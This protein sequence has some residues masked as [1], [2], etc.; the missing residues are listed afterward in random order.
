MPTKKPIVLLNNHDTLDNREKRNAAEN[1]ITPTAP[2][3]HDPPPKLSGHKMASMLWKKI[4]E[5]YD[6]IDGKIATAFDEETLIN[7]VLL[8]EECEWLISIRGKVD[9]ERASVEKMIA[10]KPEIKDDAKMKNY[11][12]LL[13]QYSALLARLQGLD[14]R[15]D[16]KRKLMHTLAQSLYLTPRAR[17]GVVPPQKGTPPPADPMEAFLFRTNLNKQGVEHA[18]K[19]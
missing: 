9:K 7:F 2:L 8:W 19:N 18:K 15:L 13:A 17:A 4:V 1:S 14:A 3:P 11:L 6:S 16:G 10:K 5:L 12:N